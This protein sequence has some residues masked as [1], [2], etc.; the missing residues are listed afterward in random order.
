MTPGWGD[1]ATFAFCSPS[2]I[3]LPT[4]GVV[5]HS[6]TRASV[7]APGLNRVNRASFFLFRADF[8]ARK[9][10]RRL[11]SIHAFCRLVVIC[12]NHQ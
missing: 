1:P 7:E 2:R 8:T 3:V 6:E 10:L 9:S 11:T 4:A 5:K 12:P